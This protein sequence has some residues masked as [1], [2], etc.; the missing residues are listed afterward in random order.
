MRNLLKIKSIAVISAAL[1]LGACA[2]SNDVVSGGVFTKRKHNKGYHVNLASRNK[3]SQKTEKE[4]IAYAE[5]PVAAN[6]AIDAPVTYN[7]VTQ[8]AVSITEPTREETKVVVAETPG[9]VKEA[10]E[11]TASKTIQHY[12][13]AEKK[14]I[15]QAAKEFKKQTKKAQKE[16]NSGPEPILLYIL[17]FIIPPVAVGLATDWE[18]KPVIINIILTL[19]CGIP[20]IIHAIIVV[21]KNV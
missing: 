10:S 15:V 7:A 9:S 16:G 4:S 17:C 3:T 6:E 14:Q 12:T 5:T 11:T 21:S 18:T 8:D 13:K 19:L 1:M 20:G 2:T